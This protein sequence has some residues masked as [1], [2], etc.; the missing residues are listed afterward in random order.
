[1]RL[2]DEFGIAYI[3]GGW[4]GSNPKDAEFFERAKTEDWNHARLA[5][6]GSTCRVGGNPADDPQNR[7]LLDAAT[8]VV[9]VVGKTWTLHVAEV[10]QTTPEENL[11]IIRASLACLKS[12]GRGHIR[13]GTFLRR[14]PR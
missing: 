11:R 13:R 5:A 10:L 6:F 7:A 3:E 9:T 14:L 4:P 8:P 12:Q 1:L 2:L